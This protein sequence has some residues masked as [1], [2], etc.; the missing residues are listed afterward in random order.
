MRMK[1]PWA[2]EPKL[3]PG[4]ITALSIGGAAAEADPREQESQRA[5][6]FWNAARSKRRNWGTWRN[7]HGGHPG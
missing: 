5:P 3:K 4:A 1:L 7:C 6:R 2:W